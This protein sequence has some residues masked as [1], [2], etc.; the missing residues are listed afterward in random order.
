V[1]FQR[2]VKFRTRCWPHRRS[3][4]RLFLL[5]TLLSIFAISFAQTQETA[6][7]GTVVDP[8]G[9]K[10]AGVRIT[11][12]A[13]NPSVKSVIS[14]SDE[15]GHF[16]I[17]GIPPG[18]YQLTLEL[19]GYARSIVS[20][21]LPPG[22]NVNTSVPLSPSSL[23]GSVVD[24]GSNS[25]LRGV[26]VVVTNSAGREVSRTFTG[27]RG[28]YA[29][30]I[31]DPGPYFLTAS[32]T[33]YDD[34]SAQVLVQH[35][36]TTEYT[37]ILSRASSILINDRLMQS[38][39]NLGTLSNSVQTIFQS[40]DGAL[41][42][43]T[44]KGVS[45][46]DG[47]GFA[48]F[49]KGSGLESD[50]INCIF[51]DREG[52]LWF[53]SDR[54]ARKYDGS[55]IVFIQEL[56]GDD[57]RHIIQ[58]HQGDIWFATS[59]GVVRYGS[60]GLVR[61]D[62]GASALPSNDVRYLLEEP[63]GSS[64]WIATGAGVARFSQQRMELVKGNSAPT[65][66]V[67]CI[68]KDSA[69]TLWFGA[70]RGAIKYENGAFSLFTDVGRLLGAEINLIQQDS[71]KNLW[72]VTGEGVIVYDRRMKEAKQFFAS[73]TIRALFQDMEENLW[74][75]TSDG[76][77]KFDIYSFATLSS[78]RGL[79]NNNVHWILQDRRDGRLWLATSGGVS[80]FDGARVS[81]LE[82]LKGVPVRHIFQDS[83]DR[84]WFASDR[85]AARYDGQK[86]H[87]F[88][89]QEGLAS[90]DVRWILQDRRG[91][92]WFATD[93]GVSRYDGN[94]ITSVSEMAGDDA[95][96]ILEDSKGNLWIATGRGAMSYDGRAFVLLELGNSSGARWTAQ[97]RDGNLYFVT[98]HDIKKYDGKQLLPFDSGEELSNDD[99]RLIF[100]DRDGFLWFGTG[101]GRVKKYRQSE[102]GSMVATFV[103]ERYGIPGATI[104]SITQDKDGNL[105][106]GTDGGAVRHKPNRWC[107]TVQVSL[108][109]NG[110]ESTETNLD[111]GRYN[112]SFRFR[113]TSMKGDVKYLYRLRG[114]DDRWR[115]IGLG[116]EAAFSGLSTGNY[117]FEVI[118]VNRDLYTSSTIDIFS[119]KIDSPFW[120]KWWF[121][122]VSALSFGSLL[123]GLIAIK[124]YRERGP[125]MP[126]ELQTY[127]P[128]E[129]NPYIVGNPIRTEKMFYGRQDDFRYVS[130]K[131]ESTTQ[132]VVIVFFGERRTGKSSI[133]YQILNGRL[134]P[135]F[136]PIF[137][138]MQEMVVDSDHE[139]FGRIARMIAESVGNSRVELS[140]YSFNDS[141]QNPF[142]L[143]TDFLDEV[144]QAIGDKTLLLLIDE[145]ELLES[146]VK[147]GRLSE[148]IFTYL[149]SL[150]DS[151]ERLAFIFT[152]SRRLEERDRRYWRKMLSRANYRKVS[153]LSENDAKRLITEP[154]A[155]RMVY[156]RGVIDSIYYLTSGHPFYI[157][158]I[159]QNLVAHL[160]EQKKNYATGEDLRQVIDE[161]IDNPLPQMIYFWDGL[162]SDEKI[163]LSLLAEVLP[164]GHNYA[165]SAHL[166][167]AI[168]K[169][170][171]PANMTQETIHLTLE[172]L[173][174]TDVLAKS[175]QDSYRFR[176][177]LMRVWIKRSHSMWQV[178]KEVLRL[179]SDLRR[180]AQDVRQET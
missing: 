158:V 142:R 149:A 125:A 100:Q 170:Q 22:S 147:D 164:D 166:E 114:F 14:L 52:N 53:G 115:F 106:F 5:L 67:K 96:H 97:D 11:A 78:N 66:L 178:M 140:K 163:T 26:A 51:Q 50:S 103:R 79:I 47:Y 95:R 138:D 161:I 93:R 72:F 49:G 8:D 4:K 180:P 15:N 133:L 146:K 145:Y 16:V 28:D 82:E 25:P 129:P 98:E 69:G 3:L 75:G 105:W 111:Y 131:L 107:P 168:R 1:A 20:I 177:G 55:K 83:N 159:C 86:L 139:F 119:F 101:S 27:D 152:G 18:K 109:V 56:A 77:T 130:A 65:G 127:V 45:R 113:G 134:G 87:Y 126:P 24:A 21:N 40:R 71:E 157:Q 12:R 10:L 91:T 48:S 34:G 120:R 85:G 80:L 68:L 123:A 124:Q 30:G 165:T 90:N 176:I 172:E 57:V 32:L 160:N 46:F 102:A 135:R 70:R 122:A 144:L 117:T 136:I 39:N 81:T 38:Y 154:V 54:G 9:A 156:G 76:A 60:G 42:L 36:K 173:F 94:Q 153:F 84:L 2:A 110:R 59:H 29:F 143:F 73:S 116:E 64:V 104:H 112:I 132:V 63:D 141:L 58:D 74:I 150:M 7:Q 121:Y 19:D 148:D 33:G 128:I 167:R 89:D 174:R 155:G 151:R 169:N 171:Y 31:L 162:N 175:F 88:S 108:S 61:F 44:A 35:Q 43:G 137:I 13:E 62:E 17:S 37:L 41:W 6:I 92:V 99:V 179:P 23:Q 118:S